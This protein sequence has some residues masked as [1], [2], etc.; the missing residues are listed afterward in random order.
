MFLFGAKEVKKDSASSRLAAC[1]Q[2]SPF[3]SFDC[4]L[5][6]RQVSMWPLE[7]QPVE[8]QPWTESST[9]LCQWGTSLWREALLGR[10]LTT[11][12]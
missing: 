12:L 9:F 5:A 7:G 2:S 3:L 8:E 4:Y 1:R 10:L 6:S 11:M